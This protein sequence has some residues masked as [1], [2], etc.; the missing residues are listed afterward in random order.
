MLNQ[1]DKKQKN[2]VNIKANLSAYVGKLKMMFVKI[3]KIPCLQKNVL[4]ILK[5]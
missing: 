2:A 1:K 3:S 4:M 5:Y